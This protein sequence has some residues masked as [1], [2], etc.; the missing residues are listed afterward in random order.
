MTEK[1][2]GVSFARHNTILAICTAY[3]SGFDHGLKHDQSANPYEQFSNECVAYRIGYEVG[4]KRNAK[5]AAA[6]VY[7]EDFSDPQCLVSYHQPEHPEYE[8]CDCNA[9]YR[10][11]PVGRYRVFNQD[12]SIA[13]EGVAIGTPSNYRCVPPAAVNNEQRVIANPAQVSPV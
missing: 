7:R 5:P 13:A 2:S 12:W 3:G 9:P 8:R 1:F 4:T 11:V 6:F 10:Q